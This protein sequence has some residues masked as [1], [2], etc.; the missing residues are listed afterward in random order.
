[1]PKNYIY[2]LSK[3]RPNVLLMG[4]GF[5]LLI[6]EQK[7]YS[8]SSIL[9]SWCEQSNS[10]DF[11]KVPYPILTMVYGKNRKNELLASFDKFPYMNNQHLNKLVN[12]GI[13]TI[14][15][16]NYTYEVEHAI[17][18]DYP[19][20]EKTTSVA[21]S[22]FKDKNNKTRLENHLL[23]KTFNSFNHDNRQIDVWHIHGELR[24]KRSIII[25]HDEYERLTGRI[26][27]HIKTVNTKYRSN[28]NAFSFESWIDYI[29]FGNLYIVGLGLNF[30]EYDLWWILNQRKEYDGLFDDACVFYEPRSQKEYGKYSLLDKMDVKVEHLDIGVG[31]SEFL[32]YK[33][34]YNKAMNDIQ[35]RIKEGPNK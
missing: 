34:F 8:L 5:N 7:D 28:K 4:N 17:N 19:S 18:K 12:L 10:K 2:D 16:T 3:E 30:S 27:E 9:S 35:N 1:M 33:N 21:K 25:T 24:N 26:N 29:L 11:E 32:D 6:N 23:I 14:L 15:T 13:D 22:F 31:M 20:V